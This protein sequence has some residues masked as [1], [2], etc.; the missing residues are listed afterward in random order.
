MVLGLNLTSNWGLSVWRLHIL[1]LHGFP[2]GATVSS[3][4]PKTFI[5]GQL[6]IL[7]CLLVCMAVHLCFISAIDC[8]RADRVQVSFFSPITGMDNWLMN[9]KEWV[10]SCFYFC[11]QSTWVK[12]TFPVSLQLKSNTMLICKVLDCFFFFWSNSR[13]VCIA[14]KNYKPPVPASILMTLPFEAVAMAT[15]SFIDG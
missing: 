11:P 5:L 10:S 2:S 8:W 14:Q 9:W 13:S 15:M 12:T 1:C 3:N 6:A 4:S 7:N